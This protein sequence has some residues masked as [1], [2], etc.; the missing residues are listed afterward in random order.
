MK[1]GGQLDATDCHIVT[2]V[3]DIILINRMALY[4]SCASYSQHTG[5]MSFRKSSMYEKWLLWMK[6]GGKKSS[7]CKWL[8]FQDV[9]LKCF[10]WGSGGEIEKPGMRFA[11]NSDGEAGMDRYISKLSPAAD[12]GAGTFLLVV[13][14]YCFFIL[15][16]K[17][18]SKIHIHWFDKCI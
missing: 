2:S 7:R 14:K 12:Y 11:V 6:S 10:A 16:L 15:L 3:R 1:R 8:W 5:W 13:G 18:I 17:T 4:D 9:K